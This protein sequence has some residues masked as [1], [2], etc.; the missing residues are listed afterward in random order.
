MF[1]AVG[2]RKE[3]QKKKDLWGGQDKGNAPEGCALGSYCLGLVNSSASS[4]L[5]DLS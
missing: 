4:K 2:G 3:V 1:C 5:S